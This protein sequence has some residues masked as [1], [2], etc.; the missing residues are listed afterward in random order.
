MQITDGREEFFKM[1]PVPELV[2]KFPETG[3]LFKP[4]VNLILEFSRNGNAGF[5]FFYLVN[6]F[7]LLVKYIDKELIVLIGQK[8][9]SSE[10]RPVGEGVHG[11]VDILKAYVYIGF[12]QDFV[13]LET[14]I[15]QLKAD[16]GQ[17]ISPADRSNGNISFFERI[18]Y[19]IGIGPDHPDELPFVGEKRKFVHTVYGQLAIGQGHTH[20]RAVGLGNKFTWAF[21]SA[22]EGFYQGE[23]LQIIYAD[24]GSFQDKQPSLGGQ[25]DGRSGQI[26]HP[27]CL[28]VSPTWEADHY[29]GDDYGY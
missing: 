4:V 1:N 22:A 20:R 17:G 12:Q 23:I 9:S 15:H 29:H 11:Y 7:T 19:H 2:V 16:Y 21:A 14:G 3:F 24:G 5:V 8:D 6:Y 28:L 25:E 13:H 10:K 26:G 18:E 27:G